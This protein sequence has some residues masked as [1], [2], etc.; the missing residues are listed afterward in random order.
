L[1]LKGLIKL[2]GSFVKKNKLVG[3]KTRAFEAQHKL[4]YNFLS[5]VASLSIV[6]QVTTLH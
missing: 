5:K 2:V 1:C 6:D 3:S 4:D